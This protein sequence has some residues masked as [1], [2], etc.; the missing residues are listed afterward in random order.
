[1]NLLRPDDYMNEG[2]DS[3][4]SNWLGDRTLYAN[5]RALLEQFLYL[6]DANI[7]MPVL[8]TYILA[9]TKWMK[10]VP[11]VFSYGRSGTG[12]STATL[13]ASKLRNIQLL[14][15][16]STYASMR[17]SIMS[18]KFPH[19]EDQ[20]TELDGAMLLFD[21]VNLETFGDEDK[22]QIL[23]SSYKRGTDLLAHAGK[24]GGGNVYFKC[25]IQMMMSSVHPLHTNPAYEEISRRLLIMFHEKAPVGTA[26]PLEIEEVDWSGFYEGVYVPFWNNESNIVPYLK[27][28]KAA[29]GHVYDE[30]VWSPAR[31]SLVRYLIA[32]GVAIGAW[33]NVRE[34]IDV[35]GKYWAYYDARCKSTSSDLSQYVRDWLNGRQLIP[36][37][38]L[39][40]AVAVWV[41]ENRL[42]TNPK[43]KEL[44]AVMGAFGYAKL[45]DIWV[46]Q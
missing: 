11:C 4:S 2:L 9:N 14:G 26:I 18:T 19:E 30:T 42:L 8:V 45:K 23:L 40:T 17:N 37:P 35:F 24:Q 44:G 21:N 31:K 36:H 16:S 20:D 15:S 41:A 29:K 5:T 7:Q 25:F 46:K 27:A 33:G 12:K 22:K 28:W 13:F 39:A 38:E 32:T 1:M 10:E 34:G 43:G 3:W 6:P